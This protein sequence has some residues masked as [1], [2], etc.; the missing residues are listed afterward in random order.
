MLKD[1]A[2]FRD[3]VRLIAEAEIAIGHF[4]VEQIAAVA[5]IDDH[6]VVLIDWRRVFGALGIEHSAH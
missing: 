5:F 3:I 4:P 6:Q 2:I 1:P